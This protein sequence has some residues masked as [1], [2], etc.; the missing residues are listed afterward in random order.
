M[1]TARV[2][3]LRRTP[4]AA[5]GRVPVSRPVADGARLPSGAL[6]VHALPAVLARGGGER[7]L[8]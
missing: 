4:R 8:G 5:S 2:P 6:H 1:F 3:S 7:R